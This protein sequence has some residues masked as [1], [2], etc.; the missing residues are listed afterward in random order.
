[1]K[2]VLLT[3]TLLFAN[4]V[5]ADTVAYSTTKQLREASYERYILVKGNSLNSPIQKLKDHGKLASTGPSIFYD[6]EISTSGAWTVIKLPST[7]SHWIHHN[8]TYWFLGWGPDDPNYA[9]SVVGLAINRSGS[10]YAIYGTNDTSEPQ[11]SLYGET[12][13]GISFVVNIPFDELVID[14]TSKIPKA[15]SVVSGLQLPSGLEFSKVSIE[16][17]ESLDQKNINKA[18]QRIVTL[19]APHRYFRR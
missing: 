5:S 15:P 2:Y 18:K 13:T 8:I 6:F 3:I 14:K 16:Y 11:D 12:S 4:L 19:R 7:T 10:S 9:D 17:H 1:M